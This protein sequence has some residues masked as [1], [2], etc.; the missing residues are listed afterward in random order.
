MTMKTCKKCGVTKPLTEFYRMAGMRDG[1]RNECKACNLA[2]QAAKRHADP[3]PNR[4]RALRWNRDNPERVAAKAAAYRVSG[5]KRISDRRSHLKRRFGLTLDQYDEMLQSQGGGCALCNRLPRPGKALHVDHDH[6]TG[7]V[8]G[9]SASLAT[10]PSATSRTTPPG[11][12]RRSATSPGTTS[13]NR[14]S[15]AGSAS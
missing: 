1:H 15:G 9:C 3:R 7:R 11:W 2:A 13:S 4:E 6:E 10:T 8:R 5:K 14:R 12:A